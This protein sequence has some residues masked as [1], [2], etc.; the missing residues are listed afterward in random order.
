MREGTLDLRSEDMFKKQLRPQDGF[1][2]IAL[3]YHTKRRETVRANEDV[4]LWVIDRKTFR[5]AVE[6]VIVKEYT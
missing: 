4:G 6:E 3:L 2:E 5:E 1:G